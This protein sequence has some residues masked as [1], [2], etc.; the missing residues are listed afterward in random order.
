MATQ[1]SPDSPTTD[2]RPSVL[3]TGCTPGGIGHALAVALHSSPYNYR[4]FATAR[5]VATLQP[6]QDVGIEC[7]PFDV[8]S[9]ESLNAT[10]ETVSKLVGN[11]GLDML[12]NN[13]G[14]SYP[15]PALDISL[16]TA[17]SIFQT[18]VVAVMATIQKFAPLLIT[19]KG[20]IVQIASI[21]TVMPYVFG[22]VYNA[23]KAALLQYSNTL[24]LELAPLGVSVISVITG[25]VKT[26]ITTHVT[27]E[28]P[29]NSYYSVIKPEYERRQKHSAEVGMPAAEYAA[30]VVPQIVPGGG[31]WLWKLLGWKDARSRW[32]WEGTGA[33]R[34]YFI[35]GGWFWNPLFDWYFSR[36]FA[37][38][39][40]A[41]PLKKKD[42]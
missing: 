9:S 36:L 7:I 25:G 21:T 37:L 8:T 12:I 24:R 16:E 3:V 18:N 30:K 29:A 41:A 38:A 23:S 32:V 6:L 26:N 11:R 40:V 22:S 42:V 28:L 20:T 27:Y 4:V 2:T 1:S 17:A 14:V 39:K 10:F 13:A 33:G 15:V 35:S 31:S 34:A 5:R 19:A